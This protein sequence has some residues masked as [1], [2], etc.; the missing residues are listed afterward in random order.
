MKSFKETLAKEMQDPEFRKE[1]E[2]ARRELLK[3]HI[4][5]AK[6]RKALEEARRLIKKPGKYTNAE[7]MFRDL[8]RD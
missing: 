4:P 8:N 5:N 1:Y 7:D 2:K 6:T 3:E